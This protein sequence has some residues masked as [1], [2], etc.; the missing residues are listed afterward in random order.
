MASPFDFGIDI[1]VA[2]VLRI[3]QVVTILGVTYLSVRVFR[4]V[5]RRVGGTVPSGLVSSLQQIGSWSI[6]VI[7]IVILLS[8]LQV[9][10][11]ILL[12]LLFLGG[13]AIISAYRNILTDMAAA[14]F[15]ANYQAF[16]V[17]E[18]IEIGDHY[19]RVIERNLIHTRLVTPDNE[20]V[21]IPNSFVL[22]HSIINRTRSGGLRIQIPI[23][24]KHGPALSEVEERLLD[25]GKAMKVDLVQDSNPQVR[26]QEVNEEGTRFVLMLNI[27]NPAKR[28]QIASEVQKGVHELL[29]GWA[30][31][32]QTK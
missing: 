25:I 8:Q 12:V 32:T 6:W 17:G 26:V 7:G 22:R 20:I 23:F 1:Q 4:I 11:E 5:V 21:V 9:N 24:V 30:G 29:T 3:L 27:A 18:W 31:Y 14:Q 19:G 13:I 10:I 15:I 2:L 16:K 28:D